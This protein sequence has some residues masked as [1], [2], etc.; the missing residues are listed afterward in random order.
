MYTS[1]DVGVGTEAHRRMKNNV[2]GEGLRQEAGNSS[3]GYR[4]QEAGNSSPG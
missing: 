2:K 3:P 1:L 4:K